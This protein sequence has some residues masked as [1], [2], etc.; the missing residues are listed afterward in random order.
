MSLWNEHAGASAAVTVLCASNEPWCVDRGLLR[1]GRLDRAVFVGPLQ[2]EARRHQLR[3]ELQLLGSSTLLFEPVL[4]SDSRPEFSSSEGEVDS[5]D[6]PGPSG[7]DENEEKMEWTLEQVVQ[8]SE[9]FTGA[10]LSLL[11]KR[12]VRAAAARA[13]ETRSGVGIERKREIEKICVEGRDMRA[14]LSSMSPSVSSCLLQ[15]YLDWSWSCPALCD[16]P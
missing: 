14:A 1:S 13:V 5:R 16:Q 6:T 4:K 12:A 3:S 8:W 7:R 2:T 15:K 10:D 9:G 11:V